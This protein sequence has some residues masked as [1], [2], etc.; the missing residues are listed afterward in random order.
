MAAM[1]QTSDQLTA[2]PPGRP[3]SERAAKAIITATLELLAQEGGVTGVSIEAV[4]A[5]A[6]VGKTTIYRRWPN[7]EALIVDALAALKEPLPPLPG[8]SARDDLIAFTKAF[9]SDK[10][11]KKRLDCYWSVMSGAER[12]PD[13]MARFTREVIEPR[14]EAM[15]E[16]LRRGIA[17]GELRPDLDIE[18]T[19]WLIL[20]AVTNRA[21]AFGAGPIP[22]D[23][24]ERA[25]DSLLTGI[26]LR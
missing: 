11:D 8:E 6:C 20:G 15:R 3:R 9:V 7:K 17:N 22:D 16:V 19:L 21:R 14:R 24:A 13:L 26:S 12:Y 4:A 23:F 10:S 5:R 1:T 2:R 25:V 18:M